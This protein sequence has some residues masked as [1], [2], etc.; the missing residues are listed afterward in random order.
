MVKSRVET[1]LFWQ[2][3]PLRKDGNY[4]WYFLIVNTPP[5][6]A[7]TKAKLQTGLSSL[8]VFEILGDTIPG[9][10]F[11]YEFI[12]VHSPA[13]KILWKNVYREKG[14]RKTCPELRLRALQR[15]WGNDISKKIAEVYRGR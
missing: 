2:R 8:E 6:I 7:T 15:G 4:E 9:S 14:H 1:R 10:G 3:G 12:C 13:P 11:S 5:N